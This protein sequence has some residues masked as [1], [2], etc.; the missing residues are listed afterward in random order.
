MKD[1]ERERSKHSQD[2]F[3][4]I[5]FVFELFLTFGQRL[6]SLSTSP[7]VKT[8]SQKRVDRKKIK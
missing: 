8:N 5:I 4:V 2:R 1:R 3:F 7:Q 6:Y